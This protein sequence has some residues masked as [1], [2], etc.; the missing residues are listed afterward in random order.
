M[1]NAPSEDDG[2][3]R[4]GRA[5]REERDNPGHREDEVAARTQSV[6]RRTFEDCSNQLA[7]THSSP[8]SCT[9]LPLREPLILRSAM[10]LTWS[11]LTSAGPTGHAP[12]N[13]LE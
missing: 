10:L 6:S 11:L 1:R 13:D 4:E 7:I 8:L 3:G 2:P 12:S 9:V 5:L